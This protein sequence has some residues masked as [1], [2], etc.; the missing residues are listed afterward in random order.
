M[1]HPQVRAVLHLPPNEAKKLLPPE[2]GKHLPRVYR[3]RSV[4][5]QV[6]GLKGSV[7]QS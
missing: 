5:A 3:Q 4:R 2:G 1:V 7:G 6:G